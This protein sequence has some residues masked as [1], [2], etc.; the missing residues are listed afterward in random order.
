MNGDQGRTKVSLVVPCF[1]EEDVLPVSARALAAVIEKMVADGLADSTSNVWLV[2]DGSTDRT[3]EIICQLAATA[4]F[5]G[6]RLS[7]NFGH[8]AAV[9]SGLLSADGDAVVSVDADLQDDVSCIPKMVAE[10]RNGS[11]I[12]YGVRSSRETD[13]WFKR[14]SARGYYKLLQLLGLAVVPDHAD[15][16]LMSRRAIDAL[17]SFEEV[18]LYLRGVVPRLGFKS[19]VVKY[20]RSARAAGISKYPLRKMLALAVDGVT[21]FSS[22]PL[23]MVAAL[24]AAIF[25]A[26]IFASIWVLAIRIGTER[27]LPGWASTVLP[28][29]ALGGIQLLSLGVIGEYI[30]KI[31]METKRRPRYLVDTTVGGTPIAGAADCAVERVAA[32]VAAEFASPPR[33]PG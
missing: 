9:L 29:F 6:L 11:D 18:N 21:S 23:R 1:N 31:Y 33:T 25:V 14:N 20:A 4:R 5:R 32:G 27:A 17:R 22:A 26:T 16:R 3:W 10:Y 8:Q 15:F 24:G 7:R 30:A 12:V 13:G 19:T 2:D 28:M